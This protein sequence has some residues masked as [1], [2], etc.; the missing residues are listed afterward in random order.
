MRI[1]HSGPLVML[2]PG[3][4]PVRLLIPL[5]LE[6]ELAQTPRRPALRRNAANRPNPGQ[7][8]VAG[9]QRRSG[10]PLRLP[11]RR[12]PA[13]VGP[14]ERGAYPWPLG[15]CPHGDATNPGR[16]RRT[17]RPAAKVQAEHDSQSGERRQQDRRSPSSPSGSAPGRKSEVCG[18]PPVG[19]ILEGAGREIVLVIETVDLPRPLSMQLHVSPTPWSAHA[20]DAPSGERSGHRPLSR[21]REPLTHHPVG[22][23]PGSPWGT[24]L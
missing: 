8:D 24:L 6:A 10:V 3:V 9:T 15:T 18:I 22:R 12:P 23:R 20:A 1:R 17:D 21:L 7:R 16:G 2:T 4:C 13:A 14:H 5:L 11:G 19:L